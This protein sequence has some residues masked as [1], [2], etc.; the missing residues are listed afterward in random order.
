[1]AA[2]E[3]VEQSSMMNHVQLTNA[4]SHVHPK[5]TL[6]YAQ[7]L[8]GGIALCGNKA[9]AL[10]GVDSLAMTHRKVGLMWMM[11]NVDRLR[12]MHDGIMI[13]GRTVVS[14]NPR[15]TGWMS[16]LWCVCWIY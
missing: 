6:T 7:S 16:W 13:G 3:E 1:M 8:D 2:I 14:D 12:A 4:L 15:L 9:V 11:L 5:I 10:S